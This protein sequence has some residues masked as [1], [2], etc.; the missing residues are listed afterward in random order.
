MQQFQAFVEAQLIATEHVATSIAV[1]T[2]SNP[3]VSDGVNYSA[4]IVRG[5]RQPLPSAWLD[6][7]KTYD[8]IHEMHGTV[9]HIYVPHRRFYAAQSLFYSACRRNWFPLAAAVA[10][11]VAGAVVA[12][13]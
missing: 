4:F 12:I 5:V 7:I 10:C 8:A 2:E 11:A 1:D 6:A 13:Q 9:L 3:Y